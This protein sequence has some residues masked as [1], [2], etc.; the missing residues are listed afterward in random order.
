MKK[1]GV[2]LVM[3]ILGVSLIAVAWRLLEYGSL[4]RRSNIVGQ[5]FPARVALC[6]EIGWVKISPDNEW[7]VTPCADRPC[8]S[9]QPGLWLTRVNAGDSV[10]IGL[11]K[12][13]S[14]Y[15]GVTWSSDSSRIVFAEGSNIWLTTVNDPNDKLLLFKSTG[16]KTIKWSPDGTKLAV[17]DG[18]GKLILV[19][20]ADGDWE[21]LLEGKEGI[22][23]YPYP[24]ASARW[25]WS[26][27]GTKIVY[28][29]ATTEWTSSKLFVH[30]LWVIDVNSKER[31]DILSAGEGGWIFD[32]KWS[33]DGKKIAVSRSVYVP[34][35]V[36]PYAPLLIVSERGKILQEI[37]HKDL[38]VN[39]MH[40]SE[41]IWSPDSARLL[42]AA[43]DNTYTDVCRWYVFSV[44]TGRVQEI[45][46]P[47]G[48]RHIY[49]WTADGKGV[50]VHTKE[51]TLEVVPVTVR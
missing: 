49:K 17:V 3:I 51:D 8:T 15:Y 42:V 21:T 11:S 26:P 36:A 35:S 20:V 39:R 44:K 46:H 33:P 47:S 6:P 9:C 12:G 45:T 41:H 1:L 18:I 50:I 30:Q 4:S 27:D 10:P 48:I 2:M 31:H 22:S 14:R 19:H 32:P 29:A 23:P 25:D 7:M 43:V 16:H 37:Y 24:A 38:D 5:V 28:Q 13:E 34:E 40:V